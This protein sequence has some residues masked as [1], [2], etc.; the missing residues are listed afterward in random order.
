MEG[1][2]RRI[3]EQGVQSTR[4]CLEQESTGV[5]RGVSRRCYVPDVFDDAEGI[6][7][8]SLGEETMICR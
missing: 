5:S 2:P 6:L 8:K 3:L 1:I 4:S 7:L